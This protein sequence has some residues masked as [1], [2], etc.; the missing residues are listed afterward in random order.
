MKPI[1]K[2]VAITSGILVL[3]IPAFCQDAPPGTGDGFVH[4]GGSAQP[5]ST[6]AETRTLRSSGHA[7]SPIP[8]RLIDYA[9]FQHIIV[10]SAAER[11]RRRLTEDEFWANMKQTGVILL[12]A[13]SEVRYR[14]RHIKGAVNLPFTEFT[15]SSLGGVIPRKDSKVLIYCN[16]NFWGSPTAFA[17]KAPAA[18][19]NLSTYTALQAYGY[20]N[21]FELGPLLNVSSTK[22]PFEGTEVK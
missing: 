12:D 6:S 15:A 21:V 17:S 18:A 13:R 7:A 19:L 2:M 10:V 16:N 3:G 9:E 5:A 22:I 1:Q 4:L 8:N 20:T 14:L 11:E